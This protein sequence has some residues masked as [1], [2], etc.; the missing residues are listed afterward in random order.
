MTTEVRVDAELVE[1]A[2]RLGGHASPEQAVAA[3]LEEY[4][5]HRSHVDPLDRFETIDVEFNDDHPRTS[6]PK[7]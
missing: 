5:R 4:V 6:P 2:V 1:T 3:A 7:D